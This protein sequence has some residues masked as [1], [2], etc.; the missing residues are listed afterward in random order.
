FANAEQL[1][2]KGSDTVLPL[3]QKLAEVYLKKHP[4]KVVSVVGGGSGVGISSLIDGLTDI[5]Q[6]SR[7]IK[8]K[9]IKDAKKKGITPVE[10]VIARDALAVI[11]NPKNPVSQLTL[12]QIEGIFTGKITNW[13]ELGGKDLQ[14]V[15]YSRESSSGTYVFFRETAMS[16]IEYSNKVLLMPATGTIVQSVSQTE[17]AIGYVGHAYLTDG[18]KALKIGDGK[19]NFIEPTTANAITGI[20]PITRGLFYYTNGNPKGLVK[21]FVDFALS[22]EGQ[23]IVDEVGYIKIK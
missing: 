14:I 11:T 3:S 20:Y 6:S 17:G 1:T 23:K 22:A 16:D 19:G 12:K 5:A 7:D 15:A 21:D 2:I 9:E 13:K 4:D 8:K 10:T 18:V